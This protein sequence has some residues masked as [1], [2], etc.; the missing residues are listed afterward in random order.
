MTRIELLAPAGNL[1]C[2]KAAV[3]NGAD[4]VYLGGKNFSARA[5]AGNFDYETIDEAIEYAHLRNVKVYVTINTLLT[6]KEFNNAIRDV[7][8]YYLHHVDAFLIQDLGLY[9]YIKNN[10]PDMELHCSTQMHIHNISGVRNAKKLGFSRVVVARESTLDFIKEAC[11]EDIEIET[12]VHGAICVSYSGQCLM[13][14]STKNRSANK[15]M[16]SQCCRL[17]YSLYNEQADKVNTDTDYLLSPKDMCLINDVPKLIEAG[18]SSLKIEGRMKSSAYVGYVTSLYRRAIDDYYDH[19]QFVLTDKESY[20]L[21]VLFNRNFTNDY[22]YNKTD[23]FGQKTSNHLGVEIGK[24]INYHNNRLYIKLTHELNQFDGIRIG[25]FG[26]IVNRLYKDDLLINSGKEGDVVNIEAK[27]INDKV[28]KTLDYKLENSVNSINDKHIPLDI[29]IKIKSNEK[30][31]VK[32]LN[33]DDFLYESDI[34]PE[35]SISSPLNKDKIFK[36]FNKLIDT[37]YY[38]NNVVCDTSDSFLPISK[39]NDIRRSFIAKLNDYR[40]DNHK[41]KIIN[42]DI[43]YKDVFVDENMNQLVEENGCIYHN[44]VSYPI[45]Y[46][47]NRESQYVKDNFAV[48][49]EFGGLLLD[50]Q[51]KIAYYTLN[52]T[53][54]YAYEFLN[55]IGFKKIILSTELNN[56]QINDLIK[57][58]EYRNNVKIKPYVFSDGKRALMYIKNNPLIKYKV[59]NKF[60]IKADNHT[61]KLYSMSEALEIYEDYHHDISEQALSFVKKE[62]K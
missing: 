53:N 8:Y 23:I 31:I 45:N 44:K 62:V 27:N 47:I 38:L 12:F 43:N 34:I 59:N 33:F 9:Y 61:F 6:E 20:N 18:V 51:D 7:D 15:G 29:Y 13:S 35:I 49:S 17:S 28:Y 4:A 37:P 39:L 19:K 36:Q 11:K 25:D 40:L 22:L 26:C 46:V 48:I 1:A 57:A 21:K 14:S 55:R 10:Y 30:V 16:C 42:S 3:N 41:R 52:C 54:S 32:A 58:S 5:F 24:T 60:T 50:Y 56:D 2:L